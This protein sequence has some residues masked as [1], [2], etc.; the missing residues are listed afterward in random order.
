M[1]HIKSLFPDHEHIIIDFIIVQKITQQIILKLNYP[2]N[3]LA[4]NHNLRN[5]FFPKL[6]NVHNLPRIRANRAQLI[7]LVMT[8]LRQNLIPDILFNNLQLK[9]E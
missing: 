7:S 9:L 1:N 5:I 3:F 4:K 6:N 8:D 2:H